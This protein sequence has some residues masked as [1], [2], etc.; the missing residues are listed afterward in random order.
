MP[1]I[2]RKAW[3]NAAGSGGLLFLSSPTAEGYG[4]VHACRLSRPELV[5]GR[6]HLALAAAWGDLELE[7]FGFRETVLGGQGCSGSRFGSLRPR[8][9]ISWNVVCSPGARLSPSPSAGSAGSAPGG[10]WGGWV[11]EEGRV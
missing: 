10:G 6:D 1:G 11:T 2:S 8:Q 3:K 5:S 9:T 4:F 7:G